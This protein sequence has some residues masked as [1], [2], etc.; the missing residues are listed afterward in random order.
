MWSCAFFVF[1]LSMIVRQICSKLSINTSNFKIWHFTGLIFKVAFVLLWFSDPHVPCRIFVG[2]LCKWSQGGIQQGSLAR[3]EL[4]SHVVVCLV[5]RPPP[6][7]F[8]LN[9]YIRLHISGGVVAKLSRWTFFSVI[10]GFPHSLMIFTALS[11][12]FL[13]CSVFTVHNHRRV[14]SY[15]I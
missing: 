10:P 7:I 4:R 12:Q 8:F 1:S 3:L 6:A 5:C 2:L 9:I 15:V 13:I 14:E 11:P